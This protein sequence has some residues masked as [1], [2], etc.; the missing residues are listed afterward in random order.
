M[1]EIHK[2][3]KVGKLIATVCVSVQNSEWSESINVRKEVAN[4]GG[5]G[6]SMAVHQDLR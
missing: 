1:T 2:K 4:C 3:R 6:M 5:G